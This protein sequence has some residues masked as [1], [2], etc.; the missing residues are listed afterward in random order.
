MD[1]NRF[2][3]YLVEWYILYKVGHKNCLKG[4]LWEIMRYFSGGYIWVN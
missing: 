1:I 4:H 2:R 3:G